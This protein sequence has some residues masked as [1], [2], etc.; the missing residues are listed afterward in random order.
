MTGR[1]GG[2]TGRAS[3]ELGSVEVHL[4]VMNKVLMLC[5]N[6]HGTSNRILRVLFLE[7]FRYLRHGGSKNR[8]GSA[9]LRIKLDIYLNLVFSCDNQ[10]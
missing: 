4:S 7:W 9:I 5:I 3:R 2:L 10:T 8:M 6:V 1:V